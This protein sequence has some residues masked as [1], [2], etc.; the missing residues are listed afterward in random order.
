M[1][2]IR[3]QLG[4]FETNENRLEAESDRYRAELSEVEEGLKNGKAEIEEK[5]K[6]I[7]ELEKTIAASHT[8][9]SDAQ[10]KL[11]R[12]TARKE[13]LSAKQKS[14]FAVREELS[15]RMNALDKEV[16]RLNAQKE[17]VEETAENC[18]ILRVENPILNKI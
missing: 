8:S 7:L 14:F 17:K 10:E 18:K 12:D 4:F 9:Q 13:E 6:N 11:A 1:E 5:E 16:Y 15:G 2:K 3:Q